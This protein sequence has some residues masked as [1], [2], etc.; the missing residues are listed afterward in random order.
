[1][2]KGESPDL[3]DQFLTKDHI[4]VECVNFL[5]K[6]I[7]K[8]LSYFKTIIEPSFGNCA[9][10]KAVNVYDNLFGFDIDAIDEKFRHDFLSLNMDNVIKPCLTIGNPPFG[11][12]SNLAINFFNKAAQYSDVIAFILPKTFLKSS[13]INKLDLKF[14]KVYE[15]NIPEKSFTFRGIDYDVNCL[16]QIWI[17]SDSDLIKDYPIERVKIPKILT[18]K[19]F[20][21]V[22]YNDNHDLIIRRNGALAGKIFEPYTWTSKNHYYIQICNRSKIEEVK[23]NIQLLDLENCKVKYATSGYPSISKTELC[24]MYNDLHNVE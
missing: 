12:N 2:I 9:F 10:I 16:F 24:S 6:S 1:M 8:E 4:A 11:K 14:H 22:N 20:N 5:K 17:K 18:V 23:I 15:M 19:D 13:I 7:N 3:Y 21:F